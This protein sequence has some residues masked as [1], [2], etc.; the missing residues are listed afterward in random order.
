[1]KKNVLFVVLFIGFIF[2]L[3]GQSES[4]FEYTID[5]GKI[6]ITKYKGSVKDVR[7]TRQKISGMHR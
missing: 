5:N 2:F 6:T 3:F 1:M 7:I 4:D